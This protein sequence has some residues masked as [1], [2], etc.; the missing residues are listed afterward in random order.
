MSDKY[1]INSDLCFTASIV[2]VQQ[3][4]YIAKLLNIQE[5][6]R[7]NFFCL[8]SSTQ[9]VQNQLFRSAANKDN[10]KYMARIFFQMSLWQPD[11]SQNN[12]KASY[13]DKSV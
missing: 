9:Y 13:R 2:H 1:T 11:P 4:K 6:K 12:H 8:L 5:K 10:I 7:V 3:H